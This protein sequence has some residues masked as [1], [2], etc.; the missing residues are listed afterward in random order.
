M[1]FS[2][3]PLYFYKNDAHSI[4]GAEPSCLPIWILKVSYAYKLTTYLL[5]CL[6]LNYFH[7]ETK[8]SELQ[9]SPEAMCAVSIEG[10]REPAWEAG[11]LRWGPSVPLQRCSGASPM[12]FHQIRNILAA[13]SPKPGLC[14]V[15]QPL[16]EG[17]KLL[18]PYLFSW[19]PSTHI[20]NQPMDN[21]MPGQLW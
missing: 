17:E 16:L 14:Y 4:L 6:F 18:T 21:P 9:L 13:K 15:P 11:S 8:D 7:S 3:P 10:E 20:K 2:P 19:V 5:L 12:V 1:V